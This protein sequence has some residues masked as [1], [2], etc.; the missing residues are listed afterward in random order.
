MAEILTTLVEQ[1][2]KLAL[3]I[4]RD[5]ILL[6][7][8]VLDRVEVDHLISTLAMQRGRMEEDSGDASLPDDRSGSE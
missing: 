7:Q 5:D 4:K 6:A 3:E 8:A 2:A 1:G